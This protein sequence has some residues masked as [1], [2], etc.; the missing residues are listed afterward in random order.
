LNFGFSL[1][2]PDYC[3]VQQY[4]VAG[5]SGE[6]N[7]VLVLHYLTIVL[8]SNTLW[9]RFWLLRRGEMSAFW[10]LILQYLTICPEAAIPLWARFWLLWRGEMPVF[11]V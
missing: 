11:W 7:L 9:K 10:V 8:Y 6:M 1:A 4:L 2:I 5:C 3:P